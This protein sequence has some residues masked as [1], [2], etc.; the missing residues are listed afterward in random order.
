VAAGEEHV[1]LRI[2]DL[3]VAGAQ[4]G[5]VHVCTQLAVA[6][7]DKHR[8]AVGE[9]EAVGVGIGDEDAVAGCTGEWIDLG[10]HHRVE[11]LAAAGAEPQAIARRR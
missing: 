5:A 4:W 8:C 11:L 10:V 7:A 2:E 1:A 3:D 9:A 6:G